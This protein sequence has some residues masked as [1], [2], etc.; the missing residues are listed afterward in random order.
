MNLILNEKW[1]DNILNE[2]Y[3]L[4]EPIL[5]DKFDL[6]KYKGNNSF[7]ILGNYI[8]VGTFIDPN[9]EI[10]EKYNTLPIIF[11]TFGAVPVK[12][13]KP[14]YITLINELINLP[15]NI[16]VCYNSNMVELE[17]LRNMYVEYKNIY[18]ASYMDYKYWM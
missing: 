13:S 9:M 14:V 12:L 3:L 15:Y 1:F 4:S 8:S 10:R 7:K 2:S 18:I 11:V 17:D 6:V 5:Y 16:I